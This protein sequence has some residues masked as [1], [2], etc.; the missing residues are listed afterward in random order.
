MNSAAIKTRFAPSPTGL[1]HLGNARTALFNALHARH[2][3]GVFL[4]RIED[5]DPARSEERYVTAL[6]EDLAW[7]GLTWDEGPGADHGLGP[8]RQAARTE[9]YQRYFDELTASGKAYPCFCTE[10]ELS[11]AR[12][13]RI[14]AGQ[15]PR[16]S[17]RCFG[18]SETE[19]A[20]K[21]AQGLRA[22]LRFRVPRDA[23]VEF[24][25]LVRGP[26]RFRT[27]DIGDFIIRRSDGATAFFFSNA[28]DDALMGVTDVLRGEDHLTN[29]PRQILLQQALGLP[30]PRYGHIAL[31]VGD[32]G[33]PLSKRHGSRSVAELRAQGYLPEAVVNYLARLGHTYDDGGLMESGALAEAFDTTRLGRAPARYDSDQ[34]LYWQRSAVRELDPVRLWAW[35]GDDVVQWVPPEDSGDFMAAIRPNVAFPADALR[36]ARVLYSDE[37]E[38]TSDAD[39]A[40]R[41]A[42]ETF[43]IAA[44]GSLETHPDDFKAFTEALKQASGARGKALF[45]PLRAALTGELAGP[46]FAALLPLMGFARVRKRLEDAVALAAGDHAP[47]DTR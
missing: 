40:I 27:D 10:Q 23:T 25:D 46:E 33:A 6:Q 30:E 5:T 2:H 44:I 7:L 20:A 21:R 34:L 37:W 29:T 42:G 3:G 32:D 35:L 11:L 4:L 12:K 16:Y 39:Q 26:Q 9:L 1:L 18:L 8:Y 38:M 24:H 47:A 22:T 41:A 13:A 36:W 19:V 17:G 43:F 45:H 14:A 28:V 15:P 31:I